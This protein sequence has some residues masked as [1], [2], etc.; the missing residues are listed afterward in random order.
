MFE[1]VRIFHMHCP[2]LAIQVLLAAASQA[3]QSFIYTVLL[4]GRRGTSMAESNALAHSVTHRQNSPPRQP[5][6]PATPALALRF[7]RAPPAPVAFRFV[8]GGVE[9]RRDPGDSVELA[10]PVCVRSSSSK[11]L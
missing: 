8:R 5:A 7:F 1:L 11:I 6:H 3:V 9:A 2:V 10:L 4:A